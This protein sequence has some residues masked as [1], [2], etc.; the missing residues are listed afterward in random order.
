MCH[1]IAQQVAA[2]GYTVQEN[3]RDMA[4]NRK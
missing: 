3:H 2:L 1:A 4:R